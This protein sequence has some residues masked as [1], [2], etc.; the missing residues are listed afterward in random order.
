MG[1]I[2]GILREGTVLDN[3][4][5]IEGMLGKGGFGITYQVY[6]GRKGERKA[7]KELFPDGIVTRAP[8]GITVLPLSDK[9]Y[10]IMNH[11]KDRFLEE[12][13][14]LQSLQ[15]VEGVVS[16]F[17]FFEQNSTCYFVMEFLDG[18]SLYSI[19]KNNGKLPWGFVSKVISSVG[20]TLIQV[21]SKNYFHRDISPDNIFITADHK[22]KL[23]DF[24]NAKSLT[25]RNGE[26]LSVFLKQ[27]YAPLEQYYSK[28]V[29]GTFTDVYSL[30]CVM[31]YCL[32]GNFVPDAMSR[33]N[34]TTYKPLSSYGYATTVS[35]A[36]DRALE[37]N[38]KNRTKTM[39]EFLRETGL[40]RI[41]DEAK[42]GTTDTG[43]NGGGGK[44]GTAGARHTGTEKVQLEVVIDGWNSYYYIPANKCIVLGR[45]RSQSNIQIDEQRVS[46]K[47]CEIFYD[48][49]T[50]KVVVIDYSKNG[51]AVDG[52]LLEKETPE[53]IELGK[54]IYLGS[55]FCYVRVEKIR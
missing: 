31:Y 46:K 17:D 2:P 38:A 10:A 52:R 4:Y 47:H 30:A 54:R 23:I 29:Q 37:I 14:A 19:L 55:E 33:V 41:I 12:A 28:G 26:G 25:R 9:D 35:D 53:Q 20:N 22:V 11:S 39:Q 3:R 42:T 7:I 34:G 48:S 15:H 13:D 18:V 16:V 32:T 27:K 6:D 24:G 51:T 36:L 21:H 5:T 44:T 40:D 43:Q 8:N 1:D 50:K 49:L 45:S